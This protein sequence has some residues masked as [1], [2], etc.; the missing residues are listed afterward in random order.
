MI[1][2]IFLLLLLFFCI[3]PSLASLPLDQN[4]DGLITSKELSA[5]IINHLQSGEPA[6]AE[7]LDAAWIFWYWNGT[8][9][10][11]TD[12]ANKTIIFNKPVRRLVA[13]D[14]STLETLRSLNDTEL[15]VG[16]SKNTFDE[17]VFFPEFQH[18]QGVGTVW[19]PDIEALMKTKPDTIFIY[20]TI[21]QDSVQSIEDQVHSFDPSV[22]IVHLDLFKPESY[23]DEVR[24][25]AKILGKESEGETFLQFY[26]PVLHT[27]QTR[28]AE[29]PD[30]RRI[31]V[32]FE[33]WNAYKSAAP[34]SGYHEKITFTGGKNIFSDSPNPYPAVDPE[35]VLRLAPE[36]IIKQVGAGESIV[37][38]YN[39]PDARNMA[40]IYNNLMNRTGWNILP[41]VKNG[42]VHIIHSD[43]QGSAS[44]FIGM[45]YLAKWFYPDLFSDI[46]P[47]KT[48]REYLA[49]FQHLSFNPATEGGFVYP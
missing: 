25:A 41:A 12:S 13:F 46:D 42:N 26:E 48:H 2:F 36:C 7:L 3:S 43:I 49:R 44:H 6:S 11:V 5:A 28:I 20:A 24:K 27:I 15:V 22:R 29:I 34:G 33:G 14:G 21:S 8:S 31:S 1:R 4:T 40:P 32:Y 30:D 10:T 35:A 47:L 9:L 19:S 16:V 45:Q 23:A 37:G 38:G 17:P 18:T 39:D